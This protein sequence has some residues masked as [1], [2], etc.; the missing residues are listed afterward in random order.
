MLIKFSTKDLE[1]K[2]AHSIIERFLKLS[3]E[4]KICFVENNE[5]KNCIYYPE[6]GYKK[7]TENWRYR[8]YIDIISYLNSMKEA[9]KN[10]K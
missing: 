1:K 6:L 2:D 9:T 10:T 5:H 3:F 8:K 7:E 4:N